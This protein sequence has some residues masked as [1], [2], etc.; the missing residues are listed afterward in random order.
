MNNRASG[1]GMSHLEGEVR[2]EWKNNFAGHSVLI[3]QKSTSFQSCR[4]IWLR[5][6]YLVSK[7]SSEPPT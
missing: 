4:Y 5:T 3:M 1:K 6:I 2:L 7:T